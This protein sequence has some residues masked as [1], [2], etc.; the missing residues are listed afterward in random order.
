MFSWCSLGAYGGLDDSAYGD[1]ISCFMPDKEWS[2]RCGTRIEGYLL[3]GFSSYTNQTRCEEYDRGS[4]WGALST[5]RGKRSR[6]T[7]KTEAYE[8]N[9]GSVSYHILKH[10]RAIPEARLCFTIDHGFLIKCIF[11]IKEQLDKFGQMRMLENPELRKM[12]QEMELPRIGIKLWW[13]C[14]NIKK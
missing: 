9:P 2:S 8:Y 12:A 11:A 6:R 13:V 10:I 5:L 14:S 4:S 3:Q 7:W 1:R